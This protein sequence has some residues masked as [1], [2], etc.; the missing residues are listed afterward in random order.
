MER[1]LDPDRY[2]CSTLVKGM[3]F[4]GCT[5]MDIDRVVV[6]LKRLGA[7]A[8]QDTTTPMQG[9]RGGGREAQGNSRLLEVL[10][11][12]LLDACVTAK[13]LDRMAEIFGLMRSFNAGVSAVTFGTLIKAF[14]QAGK[15][16]R[17][18][19]VWGEMRHARIQPTAVTFGCYIDACIRNDD[20]DQAL[21]VFDAMSAEG[22]VPNAV[23]YTSL[24]RGFARAG[25]PLKALD[26]YR[27]MRERGVE[28]T[29]V[30]F[31]SILD[32]IARQLSK[33][34]EL[35]A[36]IDDM[37]NA[38]VAPDVITYSILI[39]AS[40]NAGNLNNALVLFEK[41]REEGLVFDTVAFNTLLLACSKAGRL[42]EAERIFRH[43]CDLGMRPT[44]VTISILVKMYGR[45]KQLDRAIAAAE[46]MERDSGEKPNLFVYTC[47][48]QACAQNNQVRRSWDIFNRMVRSGVEPDGITF[49]TMIH[50][51]VYLNKFEHAMC[52]VRQAYMAAPLPG[53]PEPPSD[54]SLPRPHRVVPL[55]ADVLNTLLAS[56]RRKRQAL[57]ARELEGIMNQHGVPMDARSGCSERGSPTLPSIELPELDPTVEC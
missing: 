5:V 55:Q 56:M 35:S 31:N 2:T 44:N 53:V 17:C 32:I 40:C 10:F 20:F 16:A 11:N 39:K 23:I 8:L 48:I 34:E 30:T 47:L 33:P 54:F 57:L 27:Q 52:L 41:L 51:C 4:A 25:Q 45:A 21:Q 38:E 29:T 7:T 1:G 49:G 28:A 22:M 15:L 14:G 12:T 18:V 50:G 42:P 9:G 6:L 37:R 26:F 36:V 43:M 3:H 13:D 19:E 46:Q 24:I